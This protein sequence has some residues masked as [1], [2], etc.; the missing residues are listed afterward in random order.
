MMESPLW[1]Y[2]S[3]TILVYDRACSLKLPSGTQV[4]S[5]SQIQH[6]I[7]DGFHA[8]CHGKKCPCNPRP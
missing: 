4:P 1:L 5:L 8:S 7:V 2:P 6:Y 3:L